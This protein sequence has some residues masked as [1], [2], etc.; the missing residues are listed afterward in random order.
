VTAITGS[1][2]LL[3]GLRQRLRTTNYLRK[4]VVLG[5]LI[6]VVSGIGAIFFYL[7]LELATKLFLGVLAGYTPASPVGEGG[8][9][10]TD[11]LRPWAIPLVVGLGGLISGI[12]VFRWAPEAEGHGTDAAISAFHHGA[13]RIRGRIPAIKLLSSAITIGSGGSGGREGPT[14]QI[15]AGFGSW[16]ARVLDLDARDARIAVACGMGAGIGA[17]FRAPLGGAILA[18]EIPYRDDVESEALVPAFVASIVGYSVFGAFVGYTPIFGRVAGTGF[19]DP[20]QLV[21]YALIG[22]AAGML[23]RAYVRG[24]YGATGWFKRWKFPRAAKPAV[25][26]VIVGCI[27][28]VI[29]GALGTGYGWV[30]AGLE[31]T[32]LLDLPLWIVLVLP[33]AKILATSLSIGSG[34]S[35]GIFGPGMVV[36]GLLGA[37]IWRLLE[38]VAPVVPQDPSGFVIVAMMALFGSIAH[39]PLAVMLMVAEMTDSLAMLAPAMLAIGLASLVVGDRSIYK[40]Q[41]RSRAESPAH[42]FRF[43]LPLMASVPVAHAA[44]AVRLTLSVGDTVAAARNRLAAAGLPGAPVV[45]RGRSLKG[46]IDIEDLDGADPSATLGSLDLEG[47]VVTVDDGLDD[48]LAILTESHRAWAPVSSNDELVGVVSIGDIMGAYRTALAA[49]VRLVRSAG[50]AGDL[51]EAE[52]GPASALAGSTVA[53][54]AWPRDAV[55]VSILRGT[56]VVVPRGTTRLEVGDRLTVFVTPNAREALSQVLATDLVP[57]AVAEAAEREAQA[58]ANPGEGR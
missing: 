22:L 2:P 17:I 52:I 42:Q 9:P 39:A 7:A 55:L 20:R 58:A 35:G 57:S 26:G 54:A 30:Q 33:F 34:G 46:S 3:H 51:V 45:D 25:A 48:A 36:G 11:A 19:T 31:R 28:L 21:Y 29:P 10:I 50:A 18:A 32:T 38:P 8:E 47:P 49:N 41:L 5:A 23:G 40:S 56:R 4:W 44:R 1:A 14:A 27:G 24:F 15:G 53:D 13:R 37:S 43:A 16:L 6:G 12:I